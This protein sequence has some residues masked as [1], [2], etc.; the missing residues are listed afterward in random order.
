M[1]NE[2]LTAAN[3]IVSGVN[4]E[5]SDF[6]N[7]LRDSVATDKAKA[8]TGKDN[9]R[10]VKSCPIIN[11]IEEISETDR[12][13]A[14]SSIKNIEKVIVE[15]KEEFAMVDISNIDY[16]GGSKDSGGDEG[17]KVELV[18]V[19]IPKW[20]QEIERSVKSKLKRIKK[21]EYFDVEGLVRGVTRKKK[22]RGMKRVDY[23]YFM[24]DVSGSMSYSSYKGKPLL[25]ILASYIP[26]IAKK[27]DGLWVQVDGDQVITD[28]LSKLKKSDMRSIILGGGGGADFEMAVEWIKRHIDDNGITNPV[29]VMATDADEQ[30]DFQLLPNTI[31]VTT[32]VGWDKYAHHN[33]LI[34]QGFP[35][36]A[37]KQKLIVIDIDIKEED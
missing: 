4:T 14:I 25:T 29:V 8:K 30:F 32:N 15:N 34:R 26:S 36:L 33:G 27:F 31:F 11:Q 12:E 5:I 37:L 10:K 28:E 9:S 7:S 22:E 13:V 16:T 24:L 17:R 1:A 2:I 3:S 23:V 21:R 6:Y 35:S 20:V 19:G 18:D